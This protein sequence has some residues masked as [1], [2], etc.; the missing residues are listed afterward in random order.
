MIL[1]IG[2]LLGLALVRR[3]CTVPLLC[4]ASES[5]ILKAAWKAVGHPVV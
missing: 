5:D 4:V 2:A 1:A 3:S